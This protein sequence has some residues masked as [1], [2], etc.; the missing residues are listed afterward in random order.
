MWRLKIV[1]D[2]ICFVF[3]YFCRLIFYFFFLKGNNCCN[4]IFCSIDCW[5]VGMVYMGYI[6]VNIVINFKIKF[7]IIEINFY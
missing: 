5:I 6:D 1:K 3:V 4:G 2:V 7:N